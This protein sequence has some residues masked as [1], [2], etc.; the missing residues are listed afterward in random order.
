MKFFPILLLFVLN[1]CVVYLSHLGVEQIDQFGKREKIDSIL[2]E[3]KFDSE[4]RKKLEFVKNAKDFGVSEL[5]LNPESGFVYYVP[6]DREEVGWN[7]SASF[8]LEFKSYT[9]WFPIA[10]EVPY[11]GF[12]S[13]QKA[14]E[15]EKIL[16]N[17]GLDTRV[18]ITGG[19]STLGWI[20]DPIFSPQLEWSNPRLAGLVFHEMAHATVYIP[21][22]SKFNKS[23]ANFVEW[24][25]VEKFYSSQND[26]EYNKY[27]H[28]RELNRK[29]LE[30]IRETAESLKELYS[31]QLSDEQKLNEK[32]RIIE[33]FKSKVLE[34]NLVPHSSKEKF[35]NKDWNNEDFIGVL[36]YKSGDTFFQKKFQESGNDFKSF[37]EL[38]KSYK[39]LTEEDKKK[40]ME[41]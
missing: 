27:I 8:P 17:K 31:S 11:K 4:V 6:L 16:K 29:S 33:D 3:G 23:Y 39:D 25:G 10:G 7:V 22:D 36:R 37:H 30:L 2:S 12:F 20:S 24:K 32:S 15:E 28:T 38:V 14:L 1:H 9:W 13:Y 21:G 40:A 19:Y 26:P 18:R 41:E 34:R 35:L 5:A